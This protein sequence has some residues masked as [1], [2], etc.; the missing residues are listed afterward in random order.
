[1]LVSSTRDLVVGDV[2]AGSVGGH[3]A[4]LDG[5]APGTDPL[6]QQPSAFDRP[7]GATARVRSSRRVGCADEEETSVTDD[8]GDPPDDGLDPDDDGFD[9]DEGFD[10]PLDE[11]ESALVQQDLDD[12]ADFEAAFRAEGYRGVAVWCHDCVEEHYFP[13]AMLRE[14]LQTLLETGETPVHE[15]AFQPEP[16]RYVPWDYARGYVDALK[17][18]GVD[19]RLVVDGCPRCGVVLE[20]DLGRANFC[21]RCGTTL[22]AAR[23]EAALLEAGLD[24]ATVADIAAAVGVPLPSTPPE[25]PAAG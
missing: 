11:H 17:D 5:P 24:A 18:V 25:P 1:M 4:T 2:G 13:W 19:Q 15:P 6:D 9:E 7:R 10:E 14:N 23:L 12:L 20:G 16:D 3:V 21:P 22:L 8:P